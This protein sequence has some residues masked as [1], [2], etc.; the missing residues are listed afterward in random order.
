MPKYPPNTTGC[1]DDIDSV[2]LDKL[3]ISAISDIELDFMSK[4]ARAAAITIHS[5][6]QALRPYLLLQHALDVPNFT[7]GISSAFHVVRTT[8]AVTDDVGGDTVTYQSLSMASR[9]R[10]VSFIRDKIVYL[11]QTRRKF[12]GLSASITTNPLSPEEQMALVRFSDPVS[13]ISLDDE[14][15]QSLSSTGSVNSVTADRLDLIVLSGPRHIGK[16]HIMLQVA[17]LFTS[18]PAVVVF[19]IGA[20]SDLL[21]NG[22][23]SDRAK[24]I[25]FVEHVVCAC[26]AYPDVSR[27]ADRWYKATRMATDLGAMGVA[28]TVFMR[29][30]SDLCAERGITIVMFLDEYEA[31]LDIDPLLAVVN[32]RFLIERLG[33]VVLGTSSTSDSANSSTHSGK[34]SCHQCT[35]TA[36]LRPEEAMDVFLATHGHLDISDAGLERIFEAAEYHPLDIVRTLSQYENKQALLGDVE[37]KVLT[38][39]I[40]DLVFSRNLRISQ[41]HLR[42]LRDTL[43]AKAH[44]TDEP[45]VREGLA[46]E[47][48]SVDESPQLLRAKREVTRAVFAI[49]HGLDAR[50]C[51]ARDLQ[52]AEPDDSPTPTANVRCFPPA[53]AEIM[54]RAHFAGSSAE[55]Q[56]QWLFGQVRTKFDVEPRVRLR[57][58]DT[59][60]LES[61]RLRGNARRLDKAIGAMWDVDIRFANVTSFTGMRGQRIEPR[62]C[63]TFAQAADV[64]S[65][66][67]EVQQARPPTYEPVESHREMRS[68]G[69]M[70]YFPRLGFNEPWMPAD[71]RSSSHYEGSFMA[72]V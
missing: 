21:L 8:V 18:E 34:H 43:L 39:L 31:A 5:Q 40:S 44:T 48:I 62:L 47:V 15:V 58:F 60:L 49:F 17:A 4:A 71:V 16:S 12:V 38:S 19:Y 61:G 3:T 22:S 51:S 1:D 65:K 67:I 57:Y 6:L 33:V 36:A 64:V 41:M 68:A 45:L 20:C 30:L 55:E 25:Q 28:M 56:F 35:V 9:P 24:Y 14:G 63:M 46:R 70:L 29:E 7:L 53:A 72:A 37:A 54:Y 52:F 26:V 10:I 59:L 69:A 27:V 2:E 66:Y 13:E 32:I 11:G 50:H 23:D 42:Y